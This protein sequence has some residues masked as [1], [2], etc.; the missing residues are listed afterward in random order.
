[1]SPTKRVGVVSTDTPCPFD[2]RV[3]IET[4]LNQNAFPIIH[5]IGNAFSLETP[6][7]N[8]ERLDL[9]LIELAHRPSA[10]YQKIFFP[11]HETNELC[12]R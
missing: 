7:A 12:T 3:R 6:I 8:L 9:T 5:I 1:M 2:N 4:H 10:L 11:P